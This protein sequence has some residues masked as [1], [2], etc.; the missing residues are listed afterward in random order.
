VRWATV[1]L[2]I[3]QRTTMDTKTEDPAAAAAA[4]ASAMAKTTTISTIAVQSGKT[5]I[6]IALLHCGDWINLKILEI[7]PELTTLGD[8]L[9]EALELQRA[10][11]EVLRQLKNK[12]SPV[13]EL[14]RQADQLIATQR[15]RAEVYA[16]MA[17]SLGRAWKDINSLLELRKEILDLNVQY[18]TKAD[19]FFQRM[20][21]LEASCTDK[22]VPIEI[23]AVKSFLNMIHDLRRALLESLMGALQAGNTLLGKLKE[24][25]AEGTLDSRP[26]R[27]RSSVNR[28]ISQVQGWM[29]KLHLK[30]QILEATFNRRKTQLEQCLALAI[31]AADL[32]ELEDAVRERRELLANTHQLGDSTSSA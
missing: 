15:P 20:D 13:E 16:A 22:V 8:T 32:R 1:I 17:E 11:D 23:E 3:R 26:D 29:D 28:A 12:Q 10:H 2:I 14:L 9:P 30:R 6:V 7:T 27:I 19:E 18:H 25:G 4:A 5:R 31:L 21:E 24:L